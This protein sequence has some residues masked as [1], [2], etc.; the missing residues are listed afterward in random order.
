MKKKYSFS[1]RIFLECTTRVCP[2]Y[3]LCRTRPM[4]KGAARNYIWLVS[5]I[6]SVSINSPFARF[7]G[8]FVCTSFSAANEK[9]KNR[10]DPNWMSIRNDEIKH[11]KSFDSVFYVAIHIV[12]YACHSRALIKQNEKPIQTI[13]LLLFFE[14]FFIF[15]M[16]LFYFLRRPVDKNIEKIKTCEQVKMECVFYKKINVLVFGF[17]NASIKRFA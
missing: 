7:F 10:H 11:T 17:L 4:E 9:K 8:H 15:F 14:V 6:D 2:L 12:R 16:F 13:C 1:E 3:F 5:G